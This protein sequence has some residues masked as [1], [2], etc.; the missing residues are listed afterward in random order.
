MV[1]DGRAKCFGLFIR[2]DRVDV[3][4]LFAAGPF[5]IGA[6]PCRGVLSTATVRSAADLRT[7]GKRALSHQAHRRNLPADAFDRASERGANI[8]RPFLHWVL[9]PVC[10]ASIVSPEM[11]NCQQAKETF[12][13]PFELTSERLGPLPLLNHFIAQIGVEGILERFVPTRD[14]RCRLPYA[15]GL[16]VLIRSIIVE[17]E[18]IYRHQDVLAGFAPGLFGISDRDARDLKDD[19]LG[20]ALDQL[21]MA[22]RGTLLTEIVVAATQRFDV[23][24]DQLHNDSTSIK[25]TGQY[26][27]AKGRRLR[28]KQAPW[29]TYGFSKD[30]RP[31]LKQ[32]LFIL[33]TSA[34]GGIPV[35]FRCANGNTNDSTTH[36]ATWEAL[37]TAAG[38]NNFLYVADSKLCSFDNMMHID[39][40]GGRFV[41]VMPRSRKEDEWFRKRVQTDP[42]PWEP[43]WDRP[44]PRRKYGPRDRWS[45][46]TSDL[47]S[48]EG[49]PV[50][51]VYSTLLALSQKHSR[52][53]RLQQAREELDDLDRKLQ[54]PRARQRSHR[55]LA[56]QFAEI[57]ERLRVADYLKVEVWTEE[58]HR[59]RQ[60]RKGRPG[61]DTRYRRE[62]RRRLRL[63]WQTDQARIQYDENSDGMYP[64]LTNDRTLSARQVLE[65][66]K[67]QPNI[68]KRFQQTKTVHE[69]APVL[70][71][72]EGRVE[73]LFFLYF[74]AL[75]VQALIE[76]QLRGAM[77]RKHIDE[78]PLYP[79]DRSCHRPTILQIL[80]LFNLP[81][82]HALLNDG[83][84]VPAFP[85]QLTQIQNQVIGLLGVPTSA[86]S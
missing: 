41:T 55:Q 2:D 48:M 38:V 6:M 18:P 30:H 49:W 85:P 54:G 21:F 67:R 15:T 22:D 1:V 44:N 64:L 13:P 72:N 75:L 24:M 9:T 4:S 28:G 12:S 23:R 36:I 31:D 37:R 60:D 19:Q 73:A 61:K 29:I 32:L 25:F 47:P 80:R 57:L 84:L 82:R 56:D 52:I 65:A 62:T 46:Y 71:K 5:V 70:L 50:V 45:V 76:R 39:V 35:Q 63:R 10:L 43:V 53:E 7:L 8:F 14:R 86:Y 78:L 81:E 58:L 66:H 69:I 33:T 11:V 59:F 16:G 68:E 83:K 51:W 77:D 17:R 3:A 79:E 26:R 27:A 42:I 34:D 20:R 40:H 74:I